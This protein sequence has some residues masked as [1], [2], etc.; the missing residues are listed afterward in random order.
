MVTG[1]PEFRWCLYVSELHVLITGVVL[2]HRILEN[3]MNVLGLEC[4][5]MLMDH[6]FCLGFMASMVKKAFIL[7]LF[8]LPEESRTKCKRIY[9]L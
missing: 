1:R 4:R 3:F 2:V 8:F 7:H 5:K 6:H 9:P